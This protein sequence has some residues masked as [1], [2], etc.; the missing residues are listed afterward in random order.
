MQGP[1]AFISSSLSF[2]NDKEIIDTI[3]KFLNDIIFIIL[4]LY[5]IFIF[6]RGKLIINNIISR[7]FI[8]YILLIL[9]IVFMSA[10]RYSDTVDLFKTGRYLAYVPIAYFIWMKIYTSISRDDFLKLF[11][12]IL[13]V[14]LISSI[15]YVLNSSQILHIFPQENIY[16]EIQFGRRF[17][18]RDFSTIP[19]FGFLVTYASYSYLL[20][21]EKTYDNKIIYA[22]L[23]SGLAVLLFTFTR[24][25]ML[26]SAGGLFLVTM[27]YIST[28]KS[29]SNTRKIR[30]LY[31]LA[32]LIIFSGIII[33]VF[34]DQFLY[35]NS[36]LEKA[37]I[38]QSKEGN[39][40]LRIAYTERALD[41]LNYTGTQL[42]GPGFTKLHYDA[43]E[44]LGPF[45]GDS[46]L[47]VLLIHS[48]ILGTLLL[49]IIFFSAL[50]IIFKNITKK[51][52]LTISLGAMLLMNFLFS[53]LMSTLVHFPMLGMNYWALAIVENNNLWQKEESQ[54]E[55]ENIGNNITL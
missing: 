55:Y 42:L 13:Y 45:E 5:I 28:R 32:V 51:S 37:L 24:F 26:S 1:G 35:F 7:L 44:S 38:N 3:I 8:F 10:I 4:L 36:R 11:K 22:N 52:W 9:I 50:L 46:T 27:I 34:Y 6:K 47:P 33:Y 54:I 18:Y 19:I 31:F 17:F 49:Y 39:I 16:L 21:G 23:F 20:S 2:F 41:I 30:V 29:S 14:N 25:V 12:L 48:G 53:I 40:E 43:L 15:L